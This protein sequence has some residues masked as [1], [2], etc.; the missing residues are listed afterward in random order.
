MSTSVQPNII[1]THY[2]ARSGDNLYLGQMGITITKFNDSRDVI[3]VFDDGYQDIDTWKAYLAA[4]HAAGTPVT[5]YYELAEPVI[6]QH[7]PAVIPAVYPMTT[8]YAE[9]GNVSVEYNRDSN[10]VIE[11]LTNAIIKLGGTL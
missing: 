8:V 1:N 9:D 6:T 10:K 4:Q 7:D 11:T 2:P 5:V 3:Y